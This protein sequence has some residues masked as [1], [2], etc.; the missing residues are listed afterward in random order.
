M[1]TSPHNSNSVDINDI[2][3]Y[4]LDW[5]GKGETIIFLTGTGSAA[6]SFDRLA[7][8]FTDHF[9]VLALPR[10]ERSDV[11]YGLD[12]ASNDI[13]AFMEALNIEQTILVGHSITGVILT[14][15]AEKHPERISALIY[16]DAVYF[17]VRGQRNILKNSPSRAIPPP[18]EK[19]EFASVQEYIDYIKYLDPGLSGIWNSM[20]DETAI[21]DLEINS[22]GNFV[23]V[24]TSSATMQLLEDATNYNPEQ[25]NIQVPVL[26]FEAISTPIRPEYFTEEQKRVA[27]D[28]NQNQWM[29]FARQRSARFRQA[30]PQAKLIEIL[31]ANH[32]CHISHEDLVFDGLRTFFSNTK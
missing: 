3:L 16:L 32:S 5:G 30:V 17:D 14:Y 7:P 12:V 6:H 31:G 8:R 20:L 28:F 25:I 26:C 15:L 10:R 9:R 2:E 4:Y 29:P 13:I 21:Y 1:D 19:T 11:P 27:N 22:E 23:E 24:D 18:I